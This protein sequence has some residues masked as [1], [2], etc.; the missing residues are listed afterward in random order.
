[1]VAEAS[2][3][4]KLP[5]VLHFDVPVYDTPCVPARAKVR[6]AF[7]LDPQSERFR[8]AVLPGEIEEAR[9]AGETYMMDMI[10]SYPEANSILVYHGQP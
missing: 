7:D 4:D 8:L 6:V 1:M 10:R 9:V 3:A 5:E 2:G